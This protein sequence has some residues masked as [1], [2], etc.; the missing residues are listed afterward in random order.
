MDRPLSPAEFM[1]NVAVDIDIGA[2]AFR[3]HFRRFRMEN[4]IDA[5]AFQFLAVFIE[6]TRISIIV[7]VRAELGRIDENR[8]DDDITGGFRR[9]HQ[10]QMPF[11]EGTHSRD[12]SDDLAGLLLFTRKCLHFF[13]STENF[14]DCKTPL[15]YE[16]MSRNTRFIDRQGTS[17]FF[18]F[19]I[20][21][22]EEIGHDGPGNIVPYAENSA[23]N[24]RCRVEI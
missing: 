22:R 6:A 23:G 20:A 1:R 24:G 4:G 14:H 5:D 10:R 16:L 17:L 21:A 12:Q 11:M 13:D 9:P 18:G 2:V 15:K 3:I 19:F 7:F 8:S